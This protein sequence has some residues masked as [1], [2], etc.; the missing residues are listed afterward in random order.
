MCTLSDRSSYLVTSQVKNNCK[1]FYSYLRSKR[2]LKTCVGSLL[3]KDGTCTKTNQEAADV[4]ADAFGSVFVQEPQGPLQK[5]CYT[6][7]TPHTIDDIEISL[8]DVKDELERINI[9]KSQGP[10]NVHP[11]LLKSLSLNDGFVSAVTDLFATCASTGKIPLAWKEA[12][13]ISLYKKGNKKDP[14]NYRPVSLTCIICKVYEK[15]IRKHLLKHI[16]QKIHPCQHG[17]VEKKS[18]LSN[19]LESVDAMLDL[20]EEG[21]PVDIFYM[22]FAKAFDSVPHYRLLTKLENMGI[23]GKIKEKRIKTHFMTKICPKH[24]ISVRFNNLN[25]FEQKQDNFFFF[26]GNF[27]NFGDFGDFGNFGNFGNPIMC[28]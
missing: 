25:D 10:D 11:K 28:F 16:E 18:C 15:L 5:E 13:V 24:I 6:S 26:F 19:L 20:L 22:D 23:T 7:D 12:I 27:G 9:S 2:I 8:S 3:R 21:F 4:L 14:L 17:F 1:P